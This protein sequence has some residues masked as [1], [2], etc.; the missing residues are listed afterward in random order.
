MPVIVFVEIVF[1]LVLRVVKFVPNTIP[2]D[3]FV[4]LCSVSSI[5][6]VNV[7]KFVDKESADAVVVVK[8]PPMIDPVEIQLVEIEFAVRLPTVNILAKTLMA[9]RLSNAPVKV[10]NAVVEIVFVLKTPIVAVL[11]IMNCVD[12]FSIR[13]TNEDALNE[14]AVNVL[15]EISVV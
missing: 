9:L 1:V 12:K 6:V 7:N 8:L 3:I 13:S 11:V 10:L 15:T 5:K 2:V 14:I 4:V